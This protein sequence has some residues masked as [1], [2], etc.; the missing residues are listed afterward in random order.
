MAGLL[1]LTAPVVISVL[2]VTWYLKVRVRPRSDAPPMVP[3]IVPWLG[4]SIDMAKDA[5]SFFTNATAKYGNIFGVQAVG[6][7]RY[8]VTH[9]TLAKQIHKMSKQFVFTPY[10][11]HLSQKVFGMKR[12]TTEE[13]EF[14]ADGFF[15]TVH[16]LMAPSEI[17]KNLV[18]TYAKYAAQEIAAYVPSPTPVAARDLLYNI[19]FRA[20]AYAFFGPQFDADG[21]IADFIAFDKAFPLIMLDVPWPLTVPGQQAYEGIIKHMKKYVEKTNGNGGEYMEYMANHARNYHVEHEIPALGL[22]LLWALE[23]NAPLAAYWAVVLSLFSKNGLAPLVA[24][25]DTA[26]ATWEAANPN[27]SVAKNPDFFVAQANLPLLSATIQETLRYAT[28]SFS[29]RRV[30]EPTTFAGFNFKIGEELVINGRSSQLD[31]EYYPDAEI[32]DPSRFLSAGSAAG[33]GKEKVVNSPTFTAPFGGGVSMCEG[34]HF[35]QTELKVFIALLLTQLDIS[36]APGAKPE[37]AALDSTRIGLGVIHP[38]RDVMLLVRR[39]DA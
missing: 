39:R 18:P 13:T 7:Y 35:A 34:R 36:L 6:F 14:F 19:L 37:D 28:S 10:R 32:F 38:K 1:L 21:C 23:A 20:S 24:E 22:T 4:S 26:R 9:P 11:I 27:L 16:R 12:T 8:F 2:L 29:I 33:S 5:D 25:A 15:E 3:Y 17:M 30:M 31:D